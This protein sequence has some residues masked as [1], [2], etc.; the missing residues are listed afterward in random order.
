MPYRFLTTFIDGLQ[1]VPD[2]KKNALI[3]Q[4]SKESP[5]VPY[6]I[7][8]KTCIMDMRWLEYFFLNMPILEG[9]AEMRLTSFL[10]NRN[11]NVPAIHQ[12]L[13]A[14][15]QRNLS[16]AV[17]YWKEYILNNP[18]TDIFS[19][20]ELDTHNL[21]IDHFVPWS[22]VLHD[23]IWNL[24]PTTRSINSSKNDR[25]PCWE[26]FFPG[27]AGIQYESY[28]WHLQN[29]S[30]NKILEDYL[31]IKPDGFT[32]NTPELTFR[33]A[34]EETLYPVYRIAKNQGFGMWEYTG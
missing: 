33:N 8:S 28:I 12:K 21:S 6:V 13:R 29:N 7:V 4:A 19:G 31:L 23:K 9:W 2:H 1:G 18:Y 10:Q 14:P 5:D 30:K 25:L 32:P 22:I 16:K 17:K 15:V 26:S 3:E 27:F 24:I 20:A 11:P 34:L